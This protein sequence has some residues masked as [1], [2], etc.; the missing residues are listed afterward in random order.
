MLPIDIT[1][2]HTP[3]ARPE[4]ALGFGQYF[5][6]HMF[7]VD[8]TEGRGWHDARVIPYAPLTLDPAASV[9]HYAQAVFE[10]MKVFRGDDERIRLFRVDRHAARLASSCERLCI[11]TLDAPDFHAAVEAL[12]RTD[13]SWVPAAATG[14][15]LYLRPFVIATE[16]FLGV[17]PAKTYAMMIIASPVGAYYERGLAPVRIWVER[18]AARAVRGGVGAAKAAGNYAAS[19]KVS[20]AA[21]KRGYDQVLWTDALTHELVEEVGT[22][23]LFVVI[24]DSV[25]TPRLDDGTILPGITRDSILALLRARGLDVSERALRLDELRAA[26]ANGT[27]RE[28]FGTGTAAVVS[29]VGTLGTTDGELTIGDGTPGELARSLH[30][31]L[32]GIQAGR[33]AD[34]FGWT[35][36]LDG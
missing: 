31:E 34:P 22:M 19:L 20:M 8:Y 21:K 15:A 4:G 36:V 29:A 12:V 26:H 32:T 13:A 30:A 14:G 11:P 35:Q 9:F 25:I 16:A 6:D 3:K 24:G 1:P 7:R 28:V 10:G 33:L 17:R 27:L 5:S 23:N 18:E 2:T